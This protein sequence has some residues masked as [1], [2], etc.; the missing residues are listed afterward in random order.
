[1]KRLVLFA[2]MEPVKCERLESLDILR[3]FDMMAFAAGDW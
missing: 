1:M 2:I 3:G